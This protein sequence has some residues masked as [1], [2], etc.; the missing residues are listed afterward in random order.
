MAFRRKRL[1]RRSGRKSRMTHWHWTA[2]RASGIVLETGENE[3]F[4]YFSA[5][6]RWPSGFV[7]PRND[8]LMPSDETLVRTIQ[9]VIIG[10]NPASL[11]P[12]YIPAMQACWG[13]IAFDGGRNPESFNNAVWNRTDDFAPP[14]PHA[15]ANEDW[16]LRVPSIFIQDASFQG[17]G[18]DIF[19]QSRAM[20]KLPPGTGILG[21]FGAITLGIGPGIGAN[22]TF[23]VGV[24]CRQ[25]LRS[26]YTA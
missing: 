15:D 3:N 7:D 13:L 14:H 5:W 26:G 12:G 21:V 18:E 24:D 20:R 25:A 1:S 22:R 8:H 16:I 4:E 9:N 17:P 11:L 10:V 23:E 19:I 6:M 2:L